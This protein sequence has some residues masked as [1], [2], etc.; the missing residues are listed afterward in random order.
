MSAE[1]V[2]RSKIATKDYRKLAKELQPGLELYLLRDPPPAGAPVY[3]FQHTMKTGG[4]AFRAL[5]YQNLQPVADLELHDVPKWS[6]EFDRVYEELAAQLSPAQRERMDWVA[7]HS[8]C[9]LIPFLERPVRPVTIVRDPLDRTLSR[10]FFG[11]SPEPRD[12]SLER[13]R[14]V[15]ANFERKVGARAGRGRVLGEYVNGQSTILL[16]PHFDTSGLRVTNGPP[17]DADLWRE[18]LFQVAGTYTLLVQDRLR[19][20]AA[21]L[22]REVGWTADAIPSVRVNAN[23][24]PP[25]T[26]DDDLRATIRAFNWL[27]LELY[28]YAVAELD[29]QRAEDDSRPG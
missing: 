20:S 22:A 21:L 2:E 3:V 14:G 25:E 10:F 7:G 9:H 17:A 15:F 28:R 11:S 13:L 12:R 19:E 29:R 1:G 5:L 8:A 6:K 26:V 24:P 16:E 18:R 4:T 23:R 27:D